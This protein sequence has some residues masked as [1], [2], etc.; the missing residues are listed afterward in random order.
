VYSILYMS[1][2][3]TKLVFAISL[4]SNPREKKEVIEEIKKNGGEINFGITKNTTHLITSEKEINDVSFN[5]KSAYKIGCWVVL[6][7]F[8]FDSVRFGKKEQEWN[9]TIINSERAC[10]LAENEEELVLQNIHQA[11]SNIT[12]LCVGVG[13]V[14]SAF[15][16]AIHNIR[17][18]SIAILS[19]YRNDTFRGTIKET[20]HT[21]YKTIS[22]PPARRIEV[23]EIKPTSQK[24]TIT[25]SF[26]SSY[27]SSFKSSSLPRRTI[28]SKPLSSKL[29]NGFNERAAQ[30]RREF[31]EKM[32]R[33]DEIKQR[34]EQERQKKRR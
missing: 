16:D 31:D 26:T 13:T 19:E 5:V 25:S 30:K 15:T 27:T 12:N 14:E 20:L 9:H 34:K 4:T 10:T 21:L 7:T 2:V 29:D 1:G 22:H 6:P 11:V 24:S 33:Q 17:S 8:I 28:T 3:F 23:G 18:I 32:K